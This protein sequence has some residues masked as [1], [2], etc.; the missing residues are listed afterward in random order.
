MPEPSPDR[1]E[2]RSLSLSLLLLAT[3]LAAVVRI[4]PHPWNFTPLGALGLYGGARLRSW[5]VF[6]LPLAAMFVTDIALWVALKNPPFNPFVYGA[7]L[8]YVLL[9]RFV[10]GRSESLWRIGAATLTGAVVF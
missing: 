8:V 9:G 7:F 3:A 6:V 1:P 4:V 2:S 5:Q 10:V